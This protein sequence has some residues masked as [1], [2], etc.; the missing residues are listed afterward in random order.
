[1]RLHPTLSPTYG[2][3]AELLAIHLLRELT[4]LQR[5]ERTTNVAE[6][7][8]LVG[9]RRSDAR[10]VL[11]RLHRQGYVDVTR[12]RVTLMGFAVGASLDG[13][14]LPPIRRVARQQAA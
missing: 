10:A 7:A 8:R 12:M 2:V 14:E 13:V 6:L 3:D 11:S 1:M 9:V 5:A 4:T